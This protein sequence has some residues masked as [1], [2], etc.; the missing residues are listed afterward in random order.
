MRQPGSY[1]E[2]R[3]RG[4]HSR[5]PQ[6]APFLSAGQRPLATLRPLQE[7]APRVR[8]ANP[9][10]QTALTP[11]E[12]KRMEPTPQ[13]SIPQASI[14]RA[15]I[16]RASTRQAST[17][18]EPKPEERIPEASRPEAWKRA[19]WKRAE[20]IPQASIQQA[21]TRTGHPPMALSAP[22]LRVTGLRRSQARA[23]LAELL[24]KW[25]DMPWSSWPDS[26]GRPV[27]SP[28]KAAPARWARD[29]QSGCASDLH[30]S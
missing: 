18:E 5:S 27:C 16:R 21:S 8:F 25:S 9:M 10:R 14:R 26:G 12:R 28:T 23:G 7:S 15:S 2:R 4:R 30:P 6:R 11:R 24:Q 17:L 19:V 29:P 20:P 13:A 3:S 1:P 22:R